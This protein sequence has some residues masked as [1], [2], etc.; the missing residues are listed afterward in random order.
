MK[1]MILAAGL[2]SRMGKLTQ[3]TPKALC[4][5]QGKA[6]I[7]YHLDKFAAMNISDVVINLHYLADNI[8]NHLADHTYPFTI[9]YSYEEELLGIRDCKG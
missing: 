9:H 1:T 7:D 5:V 2:G 6:L 8:K 4:T 3:A